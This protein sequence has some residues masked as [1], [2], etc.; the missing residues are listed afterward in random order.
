MNKQKYGSDIVFYTLLVCYAISILLIVYLGNQVHEL[1]KQIIMHNTKP[2]SQEIYVD[3]FIKTYTSP[4]GSIIVNDNVYTITCY[5]P[6]A[7]RGLK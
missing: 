1:D 4:T 7:M 5:T 6:R 2:T 3:L